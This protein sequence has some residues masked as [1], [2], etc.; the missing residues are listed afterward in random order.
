[1]LIQTK[2]I[3]IKI[4]EIGSRIFLFIDYFIDSDS[5]TIQSFIFGLSKTFIIGE[6]I[7]RSTEFSNVQLVLRI[8]KYCACSTDLIDVQLI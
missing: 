3:T 5:K 8:I 6:Y 4:I 2:R 7:K 1:M